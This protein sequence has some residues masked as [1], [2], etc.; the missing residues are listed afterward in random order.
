MPADHQ[1][2]YS[3]SLENA[4]DKNFI[5]IVLFRNDILDPVTKTFYKAS[6]DVI[7]IANVQGV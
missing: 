7:W 1:A 2:F 4:I 5:G 6:R 3:E